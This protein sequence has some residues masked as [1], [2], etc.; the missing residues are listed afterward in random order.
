MKKIRIVTP[1]VSLVLGIIVI[2]G[3]GVGIGAGVNEFVFH[4]SAQGSYS[5]EAVKTVEVSEDE[6]FWFLRDS[7]HGMVYCDSPD[8]TYYLPSLSD[9]ERFLAADDLNQYRYRPEW[10]DCDD[11]AWALKGRAAENGVSLGVVTLSQWQE[12]ETHRL[13]LFIAEEDGELKAYLVEPQKDKVWPVTD[14]YRER[15]SFILF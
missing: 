7:F 11:F 4:P 9:F 1:V 14:A 5:P 13:N 2:L 15:I 8:D 10:F 12:N 6:L 3:I